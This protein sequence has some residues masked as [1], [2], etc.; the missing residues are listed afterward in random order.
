M[1]LGLLVTMV[2]AAEFIVLDEMPDGFKLINGQICDMEERCVPEVFRPT[3]EFTKIFKGQKVP[4]G[5]HITMDY[6]TG[7]KM[8]K[9]L[10]GDTSG[11]SVSKETDS[12]PAPLIHQEKEPDPA[13]NLR[14]LLTLEEKDTL[15]GLF[16]NLNTTKPADLIS[17]TLVQLSDAAHHIDVGVGI[18][19]NKGHV[20]HLLL[21]LSHQNDK[22]RASVSVLFGT[23]LSNNDI[24]QNIVLQR[25]PTFVRELITTLENES[26]V[27][28]KKRLLFALS[29]M[30][31]GNPA[32]TTA[33]IALEPYELL[34][35]LARDAKLSTKV[36]ALINDTRIVFSSTIFKQMCLVSKVLADEE[37]KAFYFSNCD[38]HDGEL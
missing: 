34:L 24:A 35:S 3:L 33:F 18:A 1:I 23:I 4:K 8:G 14:Q 11:I 28:C 32:T 38:K 31:R 2:L 9:L 6:T 5:L 26:D 29:A 25:H 13:T 17:K 12:K 20:N 15:T 27:I 22:V 21:L 36:F 16:A 37:A 19:Q 30:L 10:E 7:E